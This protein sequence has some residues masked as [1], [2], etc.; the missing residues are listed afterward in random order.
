MIESELMGLPV[1]L[2]AGVGVHRKAVPTSQ[3]SPDLGNWFTPR[4]V[5]RARRVRPAH[6]LA[7]IRTG[8][9]QAVNVAA[10]AGGRPRWRINADALAQFDRA[11]S[12]RV[13]GRTAQPKGGLGSRSAPNGQTPGRGAALDVTEYF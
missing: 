10:R 9:L 1:S 8:E 13:P 4:E 2:R 3:L 6:V 5:A 11:R 12:S 7:W